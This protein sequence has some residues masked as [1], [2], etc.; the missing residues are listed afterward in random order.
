MPGSLIHFQCPRKPWLGWCGLMRSTETD[1]HSCLRKLDGGCRWWCWNTRL[2]YQLWRITME[3]CL[4]LTSQNSLPWVTKLNTHLSIVPEGEGKVEVERARGEKV[5]SSF[6]RQPDFPVGT[7]LTRPLQE[8]LLIGRGWVLPEKKKTPGIFLNEELSEKDNASA[9]G[10][11]RVGLWTYFL[12]VLM[13]KCIY[14]LSCDYRHPRYLLL[15]LYRPGGLLSSY[16]VPL[17][18]AVTWG[19]VVCCMLHLFVV[20]TLVTL[21]TEDGYS[22]IS[23]NPS[24]LILHVLSSLYDAPW[25][26]WVVIW[27]LNLGIRTEQSPSLCTGS[28]IGCEFSQLSW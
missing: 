13:T 20:A 14:W 17:L 6:D 28:V 7:F 11:A 22:S 26:L 2:V 27:M 1:M 5:K 23:F 4:L 21:Y 12:K 16:P 19:F 18:F 3:L 10:G 15:T 8:L 25:V 24:C 9:M